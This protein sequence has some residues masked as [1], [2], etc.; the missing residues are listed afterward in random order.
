MKASSNYNFLPL[1][2]VASCAFASALPLTKRDGGR[3]TFYN[4]GLGACGELS[5]EPEWIVALNSAQYNSMGGGYPNPAVC[6][7]EI[8]IH[9]F[10]KTAIARV[11]DECPTCGWGE[12][13]FSRSLFNHLA[14]ESDGVFNMEWSWV[15]E[16]QAPP[17][18]PPAP[19]G[20]APPPP[21]SSTIQAPPEPTS[22]APPPPPET[23]VPATSSSPESS[24]PN[25]TS[26]ESPLTTSSTATELPS[27]PTSTT[28]SE[29]STIETASRT[30]SPEWASNQCWD[31]STSVTSE[32]SATETSSTTSDSSF[33]AAPQ[34]IQVDSPSND[35]W[36]P[37]VTDEAPAW[38][39]WS[40]SGAE[41]RRKVPGG[42][43]FRICL[44]LPAI[45]LAN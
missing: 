12:L 13:D 20:E 6:G 22:E 33:T 38:N 27:G 28:K 18:P 14:S 21:P 10:G 16:H 8:E 37:A 17:P 29:S 35:A 5:H 32:S 7:K 40:V 30:V 11:M 1:T 3:A 24:S 45:A 34:W 43:A 42:W 25:I 19:T 4:I 9:A 2:L 44:L 26:S 31:C 39:A 15:G 36:Y 41:A 23:I